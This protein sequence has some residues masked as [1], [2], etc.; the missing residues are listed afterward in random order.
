MAILRGKGAFTGVNLLAR[1][2]D[3]NVTKDGKTQYIDFQVDSRD[4]RGPGQQVLSLIRHE[5]SPGKF[6]NSAPFSQ[7]QYDAVKEAAGDNKTPILDKEGN[8]IG[9]LY[10]FKAN[11]MPSSR[12]DG[13]VPVLST[14]SP[15]DFPPI[16]KDTYTA[17]IETTKAAAAA[18]REARAAEAEAAQNA[19]EAATAEP[20]VAAA[21]ANVPVYEDEPSV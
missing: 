19:P 20:T 21:E 9:T 4:P 17:Q 1:T 6:N 8:A 3:D 7:S 18:A 15:S 14:A 2:Y 11:V 12:R 10:A 5:V 13:L 16:D